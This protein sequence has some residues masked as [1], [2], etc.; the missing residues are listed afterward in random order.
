MT[1]EEWRSLGVRQSPGW[2]HYLVHGVPLFIRM[3]FTMVHFLAPEPHI[4]LFKREKDPN[5]GV[6]GH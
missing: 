1:E 2:V 3:Y 6:N 4:L 5:Q